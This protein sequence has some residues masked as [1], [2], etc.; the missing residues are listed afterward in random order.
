MHPYQKVRYE[1]THWRR[2]RTLPLRQVQPRWPEHCSSTPYPAAARYASRSRRSMG[3]WSPKPHWADIAPAAYPASPRRYRRPRSEPAGWLRT[4]K[5]YFDVRH[6]YFRNVV[7]AQP[8]LACKLDMTRLTNE[9]VEIRIVAAAA[10]ADVLHRSVPHGNRMLGL[11]LVLDNVQQQPV[12]RDRIGAKHHLFGVE[13][14]L[15]I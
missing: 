7:N 10:R 13:D 5:S 15:R 11:A 12:D 1:Q 14:E 8:E 6:L 3:W 4:G 2:R 9:G